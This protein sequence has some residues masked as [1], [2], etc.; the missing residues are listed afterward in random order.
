[1][2]L[3]RVFVD[4][5]R[6]ECQGACK[7]K[8]QGELEVFCLYC[9]HDAIVETSCLYIKGNHDGTMRSRCRR[10]DVDETGY[11][12]HHVGEWKPKRRF[13]QLSSKLIYGFGGLFKAYGRAVYD[14]A[15]Q[16]IAERTAQ[17]IVLPMNSLLDI[18]DVHTKNAER[19]YFIRS[20]GYVKIGRSL[21]PEQRLGHL[22]KDKG[23]TVIPDC[24]DMSV[25]EIVATFPGGRR[26]ESSM[27]YRFHK[28]RVAGEW[29]RWSKEVREFVDSLN[30][31][32]EISV[33]DFAKAVQAEMKL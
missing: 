8:V 18:V 31:G 6:I 33:K 7:A 24:V 29:F 4:R 16:E 23:Q 17:Q 11:C 27:H 19:V 30:A 13:H 21:H 15:L 14:D 22:K 9:H 2:S 5:D 28:Y 25:A 3:Q 10:R 1:M 20:G 32:N 12:C 26:A